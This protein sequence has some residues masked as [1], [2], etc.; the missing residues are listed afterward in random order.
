MKTISIRDFL[1]PVAFTGVFLGLVFMEDRDSVLA[2]MVGHLFRAV[3][4]GRD[5]PRLH[6]NPPFSMACFTSARACGRW[7]AMFLLLSSTVD[8]GPLALTTPT[9][10]QVHTHRITPGDFDGDD[11]TDLTIFRPSN[12]TWYTRISSTGSSTEAV[13]VSETTSR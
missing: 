1:L 4:A 9:A 11:K 6:Y 10:A 8:R 12:Q 7:I 5:K 3:L 13:W 2:T